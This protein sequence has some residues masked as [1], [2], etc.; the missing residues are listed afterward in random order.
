VSADVFYI[1]AAIN[2]GV[3]ALNSLKT[4]GSIPTVASKFAVYYYMEQRTP[5]KTEEVKKFSSFYGL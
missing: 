2:L 5:S 4:E 1:T 3:V